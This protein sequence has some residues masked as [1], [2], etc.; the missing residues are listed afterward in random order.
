[1]S[2]FEKALSVMDDLFG[3]DRQFSMATVKDGIPSVRFVDTYYE[4]GC[5]YIVTHAASRKVKDISHNPN[6]A[7]CN[8]SLCRFRGLAVNIGHPLDSSNA[9]VRQRLIEIFEPWYFAHNNEADPGMCYVKVELQ[10]GFFHQDGIG[11]KIDF[12]KR[13]ATASLFEC[14]IALTE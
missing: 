12:G 9:L 1:M 7:L 3:R 10:S 5:M 2:I 11:Y 8:S 4:D 6:V 14:D 13:T